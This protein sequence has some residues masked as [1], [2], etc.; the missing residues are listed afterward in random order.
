MMMMMMM[1][2]MCKRFAQVPM[3]CVPIYNMNLAIMMQQ[4]LIFTTFSAQTKMTAEKR[5]QNE[6]FARM[7]T[8][9]ETSKMS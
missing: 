2:M 6:M 9:F 3:L 5:G 7:F 1:M 4:N 8:N